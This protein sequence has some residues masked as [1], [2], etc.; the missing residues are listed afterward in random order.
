MGKLEVFFKIFWTNYCRLILK[1]KGCVCN[2]VN[3]NRKS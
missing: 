2:K 3:V 1:I